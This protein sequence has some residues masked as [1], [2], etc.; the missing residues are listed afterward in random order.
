MRE[1]IAQRVKKTFIERLAAIAN[2]QK[3]PATA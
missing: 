1:A 2:L 3:G